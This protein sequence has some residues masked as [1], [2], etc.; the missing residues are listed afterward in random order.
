MIVANAE[1][2]KRH[3]QEI[4]DVYNE[5]VVAV[6]KITQAH[7]ALLEAIDTANRLK[8]EGITSARENI[9]RLSLL[10]G[11]LEERFA[12]MRQLPEGKSLEA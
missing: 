1:T 10:A 5:P 9:S 6:E 11:A 2:I 7:D 3:T 12:G 4:G 8:Q